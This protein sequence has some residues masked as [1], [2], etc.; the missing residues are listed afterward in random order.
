MG[1]TSQAADKR[2]RAVLP[3]VSV[4]ADPLLCPPPP[5]QGIIQK[6]GSP[7]DILREFFHMRLAYYG[8]RKALLLAVGGAGRS[9]MAHRAGLVKRCRHCRCSG[10]HATYLPNL[11]PLSSPLFPPRPVPNAEADLLRISNK[12][13]FILAVVGGQLV[14]A[15]RR[16]ADIEAELEAGGYA[17]LPKQAKRGA[18]AAQVRGAGAGAAAAASA[19]PVLGPA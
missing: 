5:L 4:A 1:K 8:R 10:G 7:E 6:Y 9:C 12:V 14:L 2:K 11:P 19:G 16:K 3:P 15:N 13:R 18:A 17:R